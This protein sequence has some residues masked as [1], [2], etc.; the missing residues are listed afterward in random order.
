MVLNTKKFIIKC[1]KFWNF[2]RLIMGLLVHSRSNIK[3]RSD[4]SL[5]ERDFSRVSK[6]LRDLAKFKTNS[7]KLQYILKVQ[8]THYL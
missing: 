2:G 7:G 6:P 4:K 8:I 3:L 5:S 1:W